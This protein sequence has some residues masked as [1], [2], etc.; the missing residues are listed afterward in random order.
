MFA[1][2]KLSI[3]SIVAVLKEGSETDRIDN[4]STS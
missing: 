1:S 2:F 3:S 4:I